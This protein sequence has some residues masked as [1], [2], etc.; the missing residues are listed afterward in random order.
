MQFERYK[1]FSIKA[2]WSFDYCTIFLNLDLETIFTSS[3][4]RDTISF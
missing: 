3:L 4:R 2:P 1:G